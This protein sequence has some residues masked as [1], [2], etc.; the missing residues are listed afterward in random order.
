[1]TSYDDYWTMKWKCAWKEMH[2]FLAL[3][4]NSRTVP[5]KPPNNKKQLQQLVYYILREASRVPSGTATRLT[6]SFVGNKLQASSRHSTHFQLKIP[7]IMFLP[8]PLP[9]RQPLVG[10]GLL[11]VEASRSQ[12]HTPHLERTPLDK[13]S[14]RRRDQYLAT[15]NA[16]RRRISTRPAG[17]EPE[18]SACERPQNNA[19]PLD[20]RSQ[21]YV[22]IQFP[23][24]QFSQWSL[25]KWFA[26]QDTV[27]IYL[28]IKPNVHVQPS[29][30][31]SF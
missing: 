23:F 29:V 4:R 22:L 11:N 16:H 17:F 20:W 1:M 15:Y 6:A 26:H 24:P 2:S 12:L 19:R 14:A 8:S 27:R 25:S 31:C 30:T 28:P 3:S 10:Q 5:E 18:I 13:W 21:I 9:A 7:T